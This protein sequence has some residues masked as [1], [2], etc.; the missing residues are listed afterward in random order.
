MKKFF[1]AGMTAA[2][3]FG[4]SATT[5]AEYDADRHSIGKFQ[6]AASLKMSFTHKRPN[7]TDSHKYQIYLEPKY[8]FDEHLSLNG[9]LEFY[10]D[11]KKSRNETPLIYVTG[12]YAP[13][14]FNVGII[15]F[16]TNEGGLIFNTGL[17]GAEVDWGDD[18]YVSLYG[19]K[20]KDDEI[21]HRRNGTFEYEDM[22]TNIFGVNVQYDTSEVGLYGGAGYYYL[23]DD[24]FRN[25]DYSR[26]GKT[27]KATIWSTNAGYRF[28]K[29]LG[30]FAAYAENTK[31]EPREYLWQG[32]I[33]YGKCGSYPRQGDWNVSAGYQRYGTNISLQ[34]TDEDVMPGARGWNVSAKYA[35]FSNV[36]VSA[37]YFNGKLISNRKETEKIT[38]AVRIYF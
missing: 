4:V 14:E 26:D 17:L 25:L 31:A 34:G 22:D 9:E 7:S 13:W 19:G 30:V 1:T 10:G 23:R 37:N 5:F 21:I 3:V 29:N 15:P 32:V 20:I 6:W 28:T 12:E 36:V 24:N 35:P 18:F 27:N 11:Y 16:Y 8:Q 2:L 33:S 38:G